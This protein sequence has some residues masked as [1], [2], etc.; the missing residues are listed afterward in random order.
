MNFTVSVVDYLSSLFDVK[1]P[2]EKELKVSKDNSV[3][4]C[5]DDRLVVQFRASNFLKVQVKHSGLTGEDWLNRLKRIDPNVLFDSSKELVGI[6]DVTYAGS[7]DV[8]GY[9]PSNLTLYYT[10][11]EKGWYAYSQGWDN[12]TLC[13]ADDFLVSGPI[14]M[15]RLYLSFT[16]N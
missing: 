1:L 11:P 10:D 13:T 14:C 15:T 9:C 16:Q 4:Y 7:Y 12:P 2:E 8:D 6:T 3:A 5:D